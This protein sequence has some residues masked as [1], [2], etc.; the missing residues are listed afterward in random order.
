MFS[1]DLLATLVFEGEHLLEVNKT[2]LAVQIMQAAYDAY[3]SLSTATPELQAVGLADDAQ[4]LGARALI[5]LCW[6]QITDSQFT[7]TILAGD[8]GSG[9]VSDTVN[10]ISSETIL[11]C[12]HALQKHSSRTADCVAVHFLAHQALQQ[13]GRMQEAE[14]EL[15]KLVTH[16]SV[17]AET[18]A[19]A[20]KSALVVPGGAESARAAFAAAQDLASSEDVS[21]IVELIEAVLSPSSQ[22]NSGGS[23]AATTF[24]TPLPPSTADEVILDLLEDEALKEALENDLESME[25]IHIL[26]WNRGCALLEAESPEWATKFFNAAILF[27][28]PQ[29]EKDA[30][31]HSKMTLALCCNAKGKYVEALE[32]LNACPDGFWQVHYLKFQT[33]LA[34]KDGVAASAALKALA[35]HPDNSIDVLRVLCCE[36]LDAGIP[37]AAKDSLCFLLEK[38]KC[39]EDDYEDQDDADAAAPRLYE[40]FRENVHANVDSTFNKSSIIRAGYEALVFQN[41]IQLELD[42]LDAASK[43]AS[44]DNPKA[45]LSKAVKTASERYSNGLTGPWDYLASLVFQLVERLE[46]VGVEKFFGTDD[47]K[48]RQLEWMVFAAW[49]AGIDAQQSEDEANIPAAA[50]LMEYCGRLC[51]MHPSPT[52][53]ILSKQKVSDKFLYHFFSSFLVISSDSIPTLHSST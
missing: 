44:D 49:N 19:F 26:C 1:L 41:L 39:S 8:S 29:T 15:L 12:V 20:I 47:G 51:V 27:I 50:S 11:K 18:C 40:D 35:A 48:W 4:N 45:E 53:G 31:V 22:P 30:V 16:E 36:A 34:A 24:G 37:N 32:H 28:N 13:A 33:C 42:T 6:A 5:L 7:S 14:T 9:G 10:S 38:L 17:S 2:K 23:A 43:A 25:N 46:V 3:N 21:L 52:T